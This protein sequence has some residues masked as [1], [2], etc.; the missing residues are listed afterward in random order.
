MQEWPPGLDHRRPFFD[1]HPRQGDVFTTFN[2][3]TPDAERF[4]LVHP[5]KAERVFPSTL[6]VSLKVEQAIVV[7]L[8]ISAHKYNI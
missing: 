7:F 1:G 8:L 2:S 5:R 6:S 3:S 4:A